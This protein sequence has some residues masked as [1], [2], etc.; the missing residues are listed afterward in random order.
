MPP[1]KFNTS[2]ANLAS[3]SADKE[4]ARTCPPAAGEDGRAARGLPCLSSNICIENDGGELPEALQ[5]GA[6]EGINALSKAH[7]R[8]ACALAWNV[9]FLAEKYG[10]E[11]LGFLTLTFADNVT[12]PNE[13]QRRFHSLCTNVIRK[14]Y[15][16]WIWVWE[17]TKA[18]RI[19]FH[20]VVALDGDIRSGF[21]FEAIERNDYKTANVTIRAEWK[22]WRDTAKR[23]GFGRTELLPVKSTAE[24][25]ARYVGKYISKHIGQREERDKGC[26]LVGYSAGARAASA[27][28]SFAS[29]GGR[30]WRQKVGVYAKAL[31]AL[32]ATPDRSP[33]PFDLIK[34]IKGPR[35]AHKDRELIASLPI[36]R[37]EVGIRTMLLESG[38]L[39]QALRLADGSLRLLDEFRSP[40]PP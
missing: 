21:D 8:S 26:K 40:G 18:G 5:G 28:F 38:E 37:D 20:L 14:R 7:K 3:L 27:R 10:L 34:F 31:G 13:A 23:Y 24:G 39:V 30:E 4:A 15:R 12:C 6:L 33:V 36:L 29:Q 17:R 32:G 22:F 9:Q 16:D 1:H 19:H 11:H 35:W 25:I 2:T